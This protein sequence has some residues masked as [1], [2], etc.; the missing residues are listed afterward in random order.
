MLYRNIKNNDE[1]RT[2]K[3]MIEKQAKKNY[4]STFYK[5]VEQIPETLDIEI[6]KV[7]GKKKST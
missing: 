7:T 3:D 1:E 6:D 5:K 4:N 2:I